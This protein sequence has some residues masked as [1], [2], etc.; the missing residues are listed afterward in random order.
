M[1]TQA[2]G[3]H[4]CRWVRPCTHRCT[5]YALTPAAQCTL[6]RSFCDRSHAIMPFVSYL[7]RLFSDT[8][9]RI[10]Q[11]PFPPTRY[12]PEN[13]YHLPVTNAPSSLSASRS[14]KLCTS[15]YSLLPYDPSLTFSRLATTRSVKLSWVNSY[16]L[17]HQLRA[18]LFRPDCID[19]D[20]SFLHS[21][22]YIIASLVLALGL[23]LHW[24][25]VAISQKTSCCVP[26]I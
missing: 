6:S 16:S 23:T 5:R 9:N 1:N 3:L 18:C 12:F 14:S 24:G 25:K 21:I 13:F 22:F 4:E 8:A 7:H 15:S 20:C 2:L 10:S 26:S 17:I 11:C 19:N